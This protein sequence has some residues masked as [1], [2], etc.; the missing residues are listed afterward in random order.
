MPC[1]KL[2][3][4]R[5]GIANDDIIFAATPWLFHLVWVIL[6]P[7]LIQVRQTAVE[8]LV[9]SA[10]DRTTL[11]HAA[12]V[13]V[14]LARSLMIPSAPHCCPQYVTP[15]PGCERVEYRSSVITLFVLYVIAFLEETAII[16]VAL[17]GANG[18]FFI[19][20]YVFI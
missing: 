15:P 4:R 10:P 12:S 9:L 1:L 8:R 20:I 16:A 19:I 6:L 2:F 18:I 13:V 5:W 3:G 17:Q 14:Q 7:I 11:K